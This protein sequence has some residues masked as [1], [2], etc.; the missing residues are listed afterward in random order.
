MQGLN[1]LLF[2]GTAAANG[3]LDNA[4]AGDVG[5]G[6]VTIPITAHG[7][8][9]GSQVYIGG[10]NNYDGSF[11]VL[12]V[13]ANTITIDARTIEPTRLGTFKA[14]T[15][16]GSETYDSGWKMKRSGFIAGIAAKLSAGVGGSEL[17]SLNI[18]SV[19]GSDFD[20]TVDSHDF[21]TVINW[22]EMYAVDDRWPVEE[23][24]IIKIAF[25]NSTTKTFGVRLFI[26]Q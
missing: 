11:K 15:F 20:V 12:A 17:M 23:G 18:D 21:N 4:A 9:V 6:L 2:N 22:A 16:T 10:S 19:R 3:T 7:L 8:K 14:E 5:A 25:A 13:A 26:A 1:Q 24:D